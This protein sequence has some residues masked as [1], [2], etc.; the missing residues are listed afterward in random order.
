M[1][2]LLLPLAGALALSAAT[3][4]DSGGWRFPIENLDPNVSPAQDFYDFAVG[5]WRKANPI[6]PEYARW[7]VFDALAADTRDKVHAILEE[8]AAKPAAEG[9]DARKVGDFY[10]S[11]MDEAAIEAAGV[12]PIAPKMQQIDAIANL[13]DLQEVIVRL[14]RIGVDAVFDFGRM[15]DPMESRQQ[16][17]VADQGGLGLPDASYYHDTDARS[18]A[19]R[20]AY[21]QHAI[22]LLQLAGEA[23]L[24][25]KRDAAT[26]I[27]IESALAGASMTR[28]ERR[29]PYATYHMLDRAALA[30]LTPHFSWPRYFA[31]V[32][33]PDIQ[34]IDVTAPRF[35]AEV[36]RL[37]TTRTL[38]DWKA[39]LRLRLVQA[40]APYLTRAF[41]EESFRFG[42]KLTGVERELPR[43]ARVLRATN[44]ALG[45]AVGKLF[46]ERHF[47]PNA[48]ARVSR[49]VDDIQSALRQTLATLAW[50]SPETR[51][52]AQEKLDLMTN[53]IGYPDVWRD[54]GGLEID[55][56]SYVQN[57]FRASA[58]E[59]RRSMAKI[60]KPTDR[61]EWEMTPQT[62]NAY[63]NPALN[64]IVFPAG[65]LQAPFFDTAAP[66]AWNY[67]AIGAVI[68]HE[69]THGFD[70][71]G[72]Q[73]DGHGNLRDWWTKEDAE[74]FHERT[75]CVAEQFSRFTVAGGVH[76]NGALV[77]GE[78]VADLGGVK[79]ALRA[80]RARVPDQ[81]TIED[82]RRD[83]VFFLSYANVW[84]SN[85]RPE[86]EQLLAI[87]DPHPP[88]RFRVNGTLANL[89]EFQAAFNI[90]DGSP[91]VHTPRCEIW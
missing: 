46:V 55:R 49:M 14:Q 2:R 77:T 15:A 51:A 87:V 68:A 11:G 85:A 54:Y 40:S 60:D 72:S 83:Q 70:D 33:R 31:L 28:V 53:K 79:L 74:R 64:E 3:T 23:P 63:Y 12:T 88:P 5:G 35:F 58:F 10:A 69:I 34:R 30:A 6:P 50:M 19:I 91:M 47:P 24:D 32:E 27:S 20:D 7:G 89:P 17:G 62:V 73:Y 37:L 80:L 9:T 71:E 67:G 43:W 86:E 22:A 65:I 1:I 81:G 38:A 21:V 42:A 4:T 25:A 13:D 52:R 66:P 59:F 39:Y 8:A 29:D 48:K 36:D 41:T 78:A 16:I 82:R 90:P 44:G 45:F 61:T 57:A 56:G 26:A 76:V 75:R 84:A 18:Q